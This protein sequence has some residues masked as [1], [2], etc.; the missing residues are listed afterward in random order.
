MALINFSGIASGIDSTALIQALLDQ[1]RAA[2]ITPLENQL[3]QLRDTNSAFDEV[4]KLLSSLQTAAGSFRA[5][6]G[7]A[8]VKNATS[9]DESTVSALASNAASSGSHTVTVTGLAKNATQSFD[10][11]F[12]AATSIINGSIDNGA[13]EADRTVT[14][15][16]GTGSEQETVEVTL[17]NTT[18]ASEF[19]N[20]FNSKSSKASAALV[21][22]G[23]TSSP[24]YAIVVSSNSQGLSDGEI[25]VSTGAEIQ[26]AGSGAF[27]SYSIEQASDATLTISGIAGTITRATNTISDVIEGVTLNLISTGSSTITVSND[28]QATSDSLDEFV[29]I[30]NDLI[31][32]IKESDQVTQEKSG[33]EIVNVFGPLA[34][35]SLDENII[36]T[37]RSALTGSSNDSGT[38]RILADLGIT[39]E[40]D[41]SLKFDAGVFAEAMAKDPS[42]LRSLTE[43]IGEKLGSI[44]G[45]I[46]QFSRFNGLVDQTINANKSQIDQIS[47]RMEDLEQYLAREQESLTARFARLESIIGQMT[48]QQN[49]LAGLLPS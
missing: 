27:N 4:K 19:V 11:R 46:A 22:T 26:T 13:A 6:N 12:A 40:R 48:S 2:M 41:G 10:D 35:T 16:I 17:T 21:N 45:V 33:G 18:T 38:V 14:Y 42:G 44:S 31:S 29:S 36:S 43:Q 3:Q 34:G 32:Y 37:L 9:S 28:P 25:A 23:T 8:V 7:G 15:T 30:F 5:L 39:T 49:A 24:S 1:R 47:K 20:S